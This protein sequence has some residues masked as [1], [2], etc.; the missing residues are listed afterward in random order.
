[1]TDTIHDVI[2][3]G[4]GPAGYTAAIYAARAELKPVVFE[5]VEFGGSLM[6]TTEVENF[7]GFAEGIQG[8]DLMDQMR[9][10]A[11][12]FGADLRMELVDRMDL[13]G[14]VKSVWVGEEEHKGRTVILAMGAAPRYL[15]APGEQELLGHGVSSC[16]TCDGFFF[17]DHDIAVIG[18][19]D[20]AME[21]AT[22]LTKFAKSVTIVHRREEFRASAIML[23]RAK[24]N[25]KIRFA[26]NKTVERVVGEGSVAALELKD[27]V[28]GE[29]SEL[30]VTAMFV[31][32]GHDPRSQMVAGQI[33][34]DESGY[35][36]VDSP[37]T[38]TSLP[39]V[40]AAGDLVDSHYQQAISAAGTGCTAAIDAEHYLAALG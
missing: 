4:S 34:L 29:T 6:T 39:G 10:Q 18:G 21:E 1:M 32:I 17:R 16:A 38:R 5:G 23:E 25:D 26:T 36:K 12:R 8:P 19:G 2:I 30:P 11:E 20:S 37:S 31:A 40:F 28:T 13:T 7:P 24:N 3:V 27:T 14:D 35:V 22:F 9:A 33:D 15:G